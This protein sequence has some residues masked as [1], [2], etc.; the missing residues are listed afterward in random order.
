MAQELETAGKLTFES[1]CFLCKDYGKFCILLSKIIVNII[2]GRK[3]LNLV[4][5]LNATEKKKAFEHEKSRG[6]FLYTTV[7][8]KL[9]SCSNLH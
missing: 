5:S 7:I 4:G 9:I 1:S 2:Y 3:I 6:T 8:L